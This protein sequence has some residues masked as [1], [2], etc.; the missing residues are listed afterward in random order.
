MEIVRDSAS[1]RR[2]GEQLCVEI[3]VRVL[4]ATTRI[5][6]LESSDSN[7]WIRI[8]GL[9]L[10]DSNRRILIVAAS[11]HS[12]ATLAPSGVGRLPGE[13]TSLRFRG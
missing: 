5:F 8:V 1:R 3:C 4:A 13:D 2:R 7:C 10:L 9:E 12:K 11:T 6:E